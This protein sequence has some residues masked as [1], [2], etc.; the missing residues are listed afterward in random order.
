MSPEYVSAFE[1]ALLANSS[2]QGI[3]IPF[4][5]YYTY[6][7]NISGKADTTFYVRKPVRYLKGVYWGAIQREFDINGPNDNYR[8]ARQRRNENGIAADAAT[9]TINKL[10]N[11]LQKLGFTSKH[12]MLR[13]TPF[14]S[15]QMDTQIR[16]Q[17][18][19]CIHCQ[20]SQH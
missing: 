6:Q 8:F 16:M 10:N 17:N 3:Q 9:N 18:A 12:L 15:C 4:T 13:K 1:S 2:A 7:Q 5:T 14:T 20:L 19:K 11:N